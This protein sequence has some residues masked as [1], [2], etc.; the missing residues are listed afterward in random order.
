VRILLVF[1]VL[2]CVVLFVAGVV[3]PRRSRRL[4]AKYAR[5]MRRGE[6]KGDRKGGRIGDLTERMLKRIRLMGQGS[7]RGGRKLRRKVGED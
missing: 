7:A 3:A 2:A 1:A 6:R 5:L 4:E